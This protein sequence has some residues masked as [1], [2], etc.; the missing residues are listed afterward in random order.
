MGRKGAISGAKGAVT[1]R[2]AFGL[3]KG[4]RLGREGC[5]FFV[6]R[7]P[8]RTKRALF[9]KERV[10]RH[11]PKRRH[12]CSEGRHICSKECRH[13]QVKKSG[14]KGSI[15]DRKSAVTDGKGAVVEKGAVTGLKVAAWRQGCF[16]G[17]YF[18]LHF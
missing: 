9:W 8:K 7:T 13:S 6:G 14:R 1:G 17:N 10:H 16:Y 5:H 11:W 15:A 3:V 2:K 4:R 18:W 12:F